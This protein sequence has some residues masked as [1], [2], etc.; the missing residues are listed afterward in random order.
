MK[1]MTILCLALLSGCASLPENVSE[2]DY[3]FCEYEAIKHAAPTN[4]GNLSMGAS[5]AAGIG[6][7]MRQRQILVACLKSRGY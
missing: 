2:Q 4:V 7:A 6:D 1:T 3:R 5:M